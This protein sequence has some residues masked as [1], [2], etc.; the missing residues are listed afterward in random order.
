MK[1]KKTNRIIILSLIGIILF[2]SLLIFILNYS[3]DDSSFSILEK[4]WINDNK[5]KVVDISVYN[6]VPIYGKNGSGVTFSMLNSFSK[7]HE[8]KFNMIPYLATNKEASLKN[9]SFK[10]LGVDEE[11]GQNDILMYEDS[12]VVVSSNNKKID[13]IEDLSGVTIGIIQDY[14]ANVSLYLSN[15]KD[16]SYMPYTSIDNLMSA[17]NSSSIE[18]IAIP[19]NMYLEHILKSEKAHVVFHIEEMKYKYV[20]QINNNEHLLNIMRKYYNK[21]K[22]ESLQEVYSDNFINLFFT[23]KNIAEALKASYNSNKYVYGFIRNM[24]YESVNNGNYVGTLSNYIKEFAKL[25]DIDFRF[26]EYENIQTL[27]EDLS[28]GRVDV[29][30]ANFNTDDLRI[31][32]ILSIGLFNEEYVVL[33]NKDITVSSVKSLIKEQVVTI[34][35]SKIHKYLTANNVKT[36]GYNNINDLLTNIDN[37]SIIVVDYGTYNYYYNKKL[38][39]YNLLYTNRLDSDYQFVIR[40]ISANSTFAKLFTYYVETINYNNIMYKYNRNFDLNDEA[41]FKTFIKY[42]FIVLAIICAVVMILITYLKRRKKS[43]KIKKEEKLKFID[44]L[45]SLKNRN[46]LNY[47]M[48][49]WDENVIYPQAIVIIDLNNIKY[50]NDN[51]GL[52]EGD[53]VIKK[54]A[55]IMIVNQLENSDIIRTAGNEFL[56]YLVGYDEKQVVAYCRKMYKDLKELPHNFGAAI[57]YSMITD[58][59]KTIDDAINEATLEMRSNKEKMS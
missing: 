10:I 58:D 25:A 36:I 45:T 2:I 22:K 38:G 17:F 57:G 18:Y 34:K 52:E 40:N 11:I 27:K 29:A 39:N 48:K 5:D 31:D 20:L 26:V 6:D 28:S 43:K 3:R 30:F 50:I 21:F 16:V 42:L 41:T 47:N 23:S 59:I 53:N 9:I 49:K 54:A 13:I 35:D 32:S 12:F 33:S 8:I 55:S 56:I 44:M 7:D 19:Y 46:Y 1:N 24:P 37:D 4:K 51:Y 15:A 14:L